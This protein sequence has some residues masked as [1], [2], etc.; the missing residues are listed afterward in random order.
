MV[1]QI[2][3]LGIKGIVLLTCMLTIAPLHAQ[4]VLKIGNNLFTAGIPTKE[5]EHYAAPLESGR[6]RQ[7]NW[8]WAACIQMVLN[9]H[10]LKIDQEQI[11]TRIFGSPI[12]LP[13]NPEHVLSALSGWAPNQFGGYSTIH[14]DYGVYSPLD[15][16]NNLAAKW[17]IIVG[18]RNRT[19]L[20]QAHAYVLTAVYYTVNQY[21]E[22]I[23]E[24][25]VLRDPFPGNPSR[26]VISWIE[27]KQRYPIY[28]KVWVQ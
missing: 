27:F 13:G 19:S 26:Q 23:I 10:G 11:V 7:E 16:I 5:F 15:I 28:F 18:L 20:Q 6:Q 2:R 3:N 12:D 17:P 21:Q 8:C 4:S 14:S 9:Y 25:V 24:H 22:P 1:H